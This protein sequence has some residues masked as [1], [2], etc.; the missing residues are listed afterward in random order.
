MVAVSRYVRGA[1]AVVVIAV[2]GCAGE[3]EPEPLSPDGGD[4]G[5]V[6]APKEPASPPDDDQGPGDDWLPPEDVQAL[7]AS[8]PPLEPDPD[9]PVDEATQREV[10]AAH[11]RYHHI[12]QSAYATASL[13]EDLAASVMTEE[14]LNALA[15]DIELYAE[16]G[17]VNRL[18]SVDVRWVRIVDRDGDALVLHEC[19]IVPPDA[20]AVDAESGEPFG[21][22]ERTI[23]VAVLYEVRYERASAG[24]PDAA[25]LASSVAAIDG[26]G[27]CDS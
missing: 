7:Y 16:E 11:E 21:E 20:I 22:D 2:A 18:S 15:Q 17:R 25:W 13:D 12:T 5:Q 1:L 26:D 24:S 27:S 23:T 3:S 10:L 14:S 6:E 8:L 19:N 4:A 9:S